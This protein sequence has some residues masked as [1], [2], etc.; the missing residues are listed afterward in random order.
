MARVTMPAET[1]GSISWSLDRRR[2]RPS[3]P[4]DLSTTHRRGCTTKPLPPAARRT[5]ISIRPNGRRATKAA[6]ARSRP[7]SQTR[8]EPHWTHGHVLLCRHH[9]WRPHGAQSRQRRP[10]RRA[11]PPEGPAPGA[12]RTRRARDRRQARLRP[13]ALPRGD[14][15]VGLRARPPRL[16]AG[17]VR[18][19]R[20]RP[21]SAARPAAHGGAPGDP[22]A[23]PGRRRPD[24]QQPEAQ[25]LRQ[26]LAGGAARLDR[27][28]RLRTC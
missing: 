10:R 16:R 17:L 7:R 6:T 14:L 22:R 8:P 28:G 27:A 5:M 1:S 11:A 21:G 19:T 9:L 24:Q 18:R 23:A 2:H 25:Q 13:R 26:G 15:G 3:P 12:V 4:S 20:G